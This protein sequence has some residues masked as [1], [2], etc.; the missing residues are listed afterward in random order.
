MAIY[1]PLRPRWNPRG[2][3]VNYVS[4]GRLVARGWPKGYHDAN[5]LGQRQ[6][7]GKMV[8]V[9]R[10]LPYLKALLTEGYSAVVKRNG[11]C[12]AG[13]VC[14]DAAGLAARPCQGAAHRWGAGPSCGVDCHTHF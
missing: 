8:Q 2:E 7:R 1:V 12:A 11:R 14:A 4:R 13:M 9:C 5:T 10:A 6:Q 3:V